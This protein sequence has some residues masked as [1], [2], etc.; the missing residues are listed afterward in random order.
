MY[1]WALHSGDTAEPPPVRGVTDDLARAMR[2]TEPYL[3]EERCFLCYIV[4]V[5]H[6][7]TVH[8]M[9][10]SYAPTGRAWIGRRNNR[11]GVTWLETETPAGPADA[12]GKAPVTPETVSALPASRAAGHPATYRSWRAGVCRGR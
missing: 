8:S 1:L 5:R 12:P 9:D 7:M 4:E 2:L 6:V 3:I 10:T 11:G